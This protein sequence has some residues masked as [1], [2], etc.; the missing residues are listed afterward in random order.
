MNKST[1]PLFRLFV[2]PD[3][4]ASVV[5][6]V[7]EGKLLDP[8]IYQFDAIELPE[9]GK[10]VETILTKIQSVEAGDLRYSGGA[11]S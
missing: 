1:F 11:F 7:G 6:P 5:I 10:S 3:G 4:L 2:R 8:G 9:P